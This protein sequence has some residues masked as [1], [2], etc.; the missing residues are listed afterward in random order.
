[1]EIKLKKANQCKYC[2]REVPIGRD[3]GVCVVCDKSFFPDKTKKKCYDDKCQACGV[4]PIEPY[5]LH[6]CCSCGYNYCGVCM[7]H[8]ELC[9]DSYPYCAECLYTEHF[10]LH[11]KDDGPDQKNAPAN[12]DYIRKVLKY[13]KEVTE[14]M[15]SLK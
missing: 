1:M 9:K 11:M 4:I 5:V 3:D 13:R 8:C 14:F 7:E 15:K 2:E 10:V 12:R 6:W